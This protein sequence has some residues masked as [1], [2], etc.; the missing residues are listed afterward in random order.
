MSFCI[1]ISGRSAVESQVNAVQEMVRVFRELLSEGV[2][3]VTNAHP[4]RAPEY[5]VVWF[6][7]DLSITF[8]KPCATASRIDG[9][10][11]HFS[12]AVSFSLS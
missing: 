11:N 2:G 6:D 5:V 12:A 1:S 7:Y 3:V 8:V 4:L 9:Q 10:F